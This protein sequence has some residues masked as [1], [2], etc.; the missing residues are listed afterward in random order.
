MIDNLENHD[1]I[2]NKYFSFYLP[3]NQE[4]QISFGEIP[5]HIV[6]DEKLIEWAP[7]IPDNENPWSVMLSDIIVNES[8]EARKM[9]QRKALHL[10]FK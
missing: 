7:L 6:S 5:D 3:E 8:P 1:A 10:R 2:K 9:L 4:G